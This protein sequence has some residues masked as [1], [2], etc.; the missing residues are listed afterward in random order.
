MLARLHPLSQQPPPSLSS[1][2]QRHGHDPVVYFRC[3]PI[4]AT[5]SLVY[6][7]WVDCILISLQHGMWEKVPNEL[8]EEIFSYLG[9]DHQRRLTPVSLVCKHFLA[10]SNCAYAPLSLPMPAVTDLV[11][12]PFGHLGFSSCP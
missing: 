2:H 10:I 1:H 11:L 9:M 6:F 3:H 12:G 5:S 8:W 7:S 4:L